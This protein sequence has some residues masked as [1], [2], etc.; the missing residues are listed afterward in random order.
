MWSDRSLCQPQSRSHRVRI[1]RSLTLECRF[2]SCLWIKGSRLRRRYSAGKVERKSLRPWTLA[3]KGIFSLRP[4]RVAEE[5]F[6]VKMLFLI[7]WISAMP[8]TRHLLIT[9]PFATLRHL[10]STVRL[11]LWFDGCDPFL[12]LSSCDHLSWTP[13]PQPPAPFTFPTHLEIIH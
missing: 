8:Y 6:R 2:P 13:P 4:I 10:T 7:R 1:K 5:D 3:K 12:I 9:E 11:H